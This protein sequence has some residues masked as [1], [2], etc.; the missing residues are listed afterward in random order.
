M[1]GK[2]HDLVNFTKKYKGELHSFHLD[3]KRWRKFKT[4]YKL[5]WQ[6]IRF[7][8]DN[9]P[10][11]PQ[12]R[13]IYVFTLELNSRKLPLHGYILYVGITGNNSDSNLYRR[14]S[15]Y[16]LHQQNQDGRPAIFY[17]LGNWPNDLFFNF[18]SLPT[19]NIDLEKLEKDFLNAIIPPVN[20]RDLD[21]TIVATRAATF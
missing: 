7:N 5:D 18:V 2:H 10:S 16:L 1:T 3:M 13:G 17:M 6:K 9:H 8:K 20:K 4:R 21:A 19:P 14:Y 11:I 12:Q 15:Q